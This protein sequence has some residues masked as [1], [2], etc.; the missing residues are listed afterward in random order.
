MDKTS[1]IQIFISH[2]AKDEAFAK[3]IVD[4]LN[5]SLNVGD[6]AIRC[7]SVAPYKLKPGDNSAD[8]LRDEIRSCDVLIALL[9]SE[10]LASKFV[11]M[12]LGAA[13]VLN[14]RVCPVLAPSVDWS[15]LPGPFASI[16]GVK[17]DDRNG[18]LSVLEVV[19]DAT[20]FKPKPRLN[21][22]ACLTN[23]L[24]TLRTLFP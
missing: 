7:T 8:T 5:G 23:T 13:W 22:D 18:L 1:P 16:H 14:R 4:L 10:S 19:Q 21:G 9:T 15:N 17:A 24:A 3:A 12:E 11:L 20:G 2:S 6:D